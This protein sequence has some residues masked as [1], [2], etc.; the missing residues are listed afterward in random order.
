V[1]L[2]LLTW[3]ASGVVETTVR[4]W[5]EGDVGSRARLVL[6]SAERSLAHAWSNPGELQDQ[7]SA[8]ARD[9]R[10]MAVA[11]CGPDLQ[12]R[13]MT[14]AF[15]QEF[16]CVEVGPRVRTVDRAAEDAS[17]PFHAWD[18]F[19]TL[20][21]GRVHVSAMPVSTNGQELGFVLLVQDL[22]YIEKRENRARTF[23]IVIFGILAVAAFGVPL[24]AAKRARYDWSLELRKL[25]RGGGMQNREFQIGAR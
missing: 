3:T 4:E 10:V 21:T 20:P 12:T 5:F 6:S 1:G 7:I 15:P 14:P 2:A 16:S 8:I 25:L 9:E 19:S 11:A 13:S 23:L 18:T 22:T 24:L 17:E